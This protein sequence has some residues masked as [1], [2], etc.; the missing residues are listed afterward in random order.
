MVKCVTTVFGLLENSCLSAFLPV[1]VMFQWS[2]VI[3]KRELKLGVCLKDFIVLILKYR[4]IM[5]PST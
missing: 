1:E 2:R 3:L 5:I 4:I